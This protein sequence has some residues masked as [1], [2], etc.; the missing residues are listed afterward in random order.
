MRV[1]FYWSEADPDFGG[2]VPVEMTER[3][4]PLLRCMKGTNSP[5]PRCA[6]LQ[7]QVGQ[8]VVCRI[9]P[10]RPSPCREF[11]IRWENGALEASP[12]ELERCNRA[13]ASYGLPPLG[14]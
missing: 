4:A 7:G 13:R 5:Q 10:Q 3:V 8:T 1:S 6:A 11:G 9:Y 12:S 2:V 14:L